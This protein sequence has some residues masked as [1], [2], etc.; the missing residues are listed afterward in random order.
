M[1]QELWIQNSCNT[2]YTR[3]M[4][5]FKRITVNC[6]HI[7]DIQRNYETQDTQFTQPIL[8]HPSQSQSAL[9]S[10][11]G[12]TSSLPCPIPS[13][14]WPVDGCPTA[15]DVSYHRGKVKAFLRIV[16]TVEFLWL[17]KTRNVSSRTDFCRTPGHSSLTFW[18]RSFTFKF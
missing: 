9:W 15:T 5:C 7:A 8:T 16:R 17:W 18:R 13:R 3:N 1:K 2:I 14:Y 6:L 10:H 4:I 12:D 11:H